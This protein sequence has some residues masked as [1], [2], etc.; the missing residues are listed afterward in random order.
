VRVDGSTGPALDARAK[1]AYRLRLQELGEELDEARRW[2]DVERAARAEEE[3][4]ALTEQ[5][6]SAL[7]LGGRDRPGGSPAERAR[8]SVT[9]AIRSAIR[10]IDRH[11]PALGA[12]L[13]TAVRTGQ[14]CSYAPPAADPP[15]WRL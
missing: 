3:I 14:F 2:A 5:L 1:E 8:V 7:G 9:K 4:D 6:T 11:S 13:S 10:S 12:H 15:H